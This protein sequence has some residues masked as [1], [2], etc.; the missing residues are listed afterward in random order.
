MG[1][2]DRIMAGTESDETW[3]RA[4]AAHLAR[5]A[6]F[7]AT[8]DELDRLV[9]LGRDGAVA[10]FVD[11]PVEDAALELLIEEQ[12]GTLVDFESGEGANIG[13][14]AEHARNWWIFRMVHGA[15]PLQEKLTLLWHDHFACQ[16]SKIIRLPQ[17]FDQNQVFRRNAAG[18]FRT[19]LR[20][21]SADPGML[22]YLDN[23]LNDRQNPNE[24]WGRELLELFTLGVDNGYTQRDVYEFS[25]VF[26]GWTT[27]DKNTA[28]YVYDAEMHDEGDKLLFG[29]TLEGRS[30]AEGEDEGH[31]A[32]ERIL[33]RRECADFIAGKLCAWFVNHEPDPERVREF[34]AVLH[35]SDYSLRETL[36]AI[37]A[38]DWFYA[39]EN[40]LNMYKNPVEFVVSAARLVGLQNAHLAPL[41]EAA[42]A[43]GMDLFEPPSVA[44]WDHGAVWVNSGTAIHRFNFALALAELPH[45]T[46][47]ITGRTAWNLDALEDSIEALTE[48][49]LQRRLPAEKLAAVT[50]VAG[51]LR[52]FDADAETLRERRRAAVHLILSTPEFA[53]G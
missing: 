18:S 3:T 17:Y 11:F 10:S 16:R 36:H 24:N 50:E 37:F 31:E 13:A 48:R 22:T 53:M 26:T 35:E 25:R 28:E 44:G 51:D 34:G 38:S 45:T 33:A 40:R 2:P 43:M 42:R 9:E 4:D 29:E 39:P 52:E 41:E 49:L 46:R 47:E 15:H 5:R 21:V 32:L 20:E 23:R 1:Y 27:P 8:P 30:G 14:V 19:L 12:G 6:G 7:G